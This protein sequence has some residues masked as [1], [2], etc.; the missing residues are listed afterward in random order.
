MIDLQKFLRYSGNKITQEEHRHSKE[1]EATVIWE[2]REAF[3]SGWGTWLPQR[4]RTL[5]GEQPGQ[6]AA[7]VQG[8]MYDVCQTE[9]TLKFAAIQRSGSGGRTVDKLSS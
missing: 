6:P 9:S 4:G 2:Q 3:G 8:T 1:K 7:T 5:S